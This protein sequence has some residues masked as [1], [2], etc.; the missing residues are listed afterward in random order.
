MNEGLRTADYG[1]EANLDWHFRLFLPGLGGRFL[2]AWH[3]AWKVPRT[4]LPALSPGRAELHFLPTADR[5]DAHPAGRADARR[6]PVHRQTAAHSQ[7]RG[8][9]KRYRWVPTGSR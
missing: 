2:P 6:F 1:P 7:P 5:G 9:H 8:K 3:P 4:L